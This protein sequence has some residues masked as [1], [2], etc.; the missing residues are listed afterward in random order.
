MINEFFLNRVTF[1]SSVSTSNELTVSDYISSGSVLYDQTGNS[2]NWNSVYTNVSNTSG[3]WNSVYSDVVNDS[4]NWDSVYTDVVNASGNWDSVY[5]DVVSTSANWNS[6]YTD[7]SNT[8]A[9]WDSVYTDVINTSGNWNSVYTDVVN[10]SGNWDSVYSEFNQNSSTYTTYNYVDNNFLPASGGSVSGS[11]EVG[12]GIT[13]TLYVENQKVGINTETPNEALT[14]VGNISANGNFYADGY[15]NQS[16]DNSTTIVENTSGNWNSV[17]TDVSNTSAE[18][19]S[20]YSDVVS[21]SGNWNSVYT[22]VVNTSAEWDSVYTTVNTNSSDNWDNSKSNEYTHTNFLPLTGGTINGAVRINDTLTVY[23]NI[24][25]TGNSYFSNTVYSTTSALSVVNIGNSGPAFYVGNNGSGDI[26]SFYDVDENLEV[27]HIGGN[28]GSHP[29]VGIKTSEPN[30]DLTINGEL[31]ASSTIWDST[32]NSNQWNSVYTTVNSNS[33]TIWNY[34]GTDIKDLSSGWV[35]GNSAF[36]NLVSNSAAYLSAV[37][38]SFLSVSGNWDSTYTTVCSNSANWN[39]AFGSAGSDLAVRGLSSGWVGGNTAFTNLVSNS[40]GYLS[41]VDLSFL[42]VSGNWDSTYTTVNSNSATIWNYQ[43]TDIKDLSSGWVGGNSAFTTV[44]SNSSNYILDGGNTKG[45]DLLIGTNDSFSLNLETNNSTKVTITSSGN[46]GIGT[47][48]PSSKLQVAYTTG[49]PASS[50]ISSD[51]IIITGQSTSPGFSIISSS[52]SSGNR[53]VFK[54]VRSRGTL[55]N[56]TVPILNDT[57]FSLLGSIFDGVSSTQATA[58]IE[59]KVDGNVSEQIAPQRISFVTSETTGS[60]RTEK[61]TIKSNGNVGIGT[62]IPNELLTVSGNISA[63]GTISS[64]NLNISNWNSV[65]TN[66]QT[67]SSK[68]VLEDFIVACSD[69]STNLT[70]TTSAVTFRVPF[71]MYLNSVRASVNQA[72]VGSTII[73]DVKQSGTSIFSTKLSIDANEETSTTAAT[74]A[75]ISN[76]NLTDDSKI[77]VS[78]DQVGSTNPGKGLKLTFKGYRI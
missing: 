60:A 62:L 54:C 2:S 46:V 39:A 3:N 18:W 74:P 11:F 73:V 47:I 57:T 65:Y 32:G 66:V 23:G 41:A 72:P 56:P 20:V 36:T 59:M 24:S 27:L 45:S 70:T 61:M 42:S 55:E 50:L 53:G 67:N 37:D 69:E 43:G 34:Q 1:L 77:I 51:A 15:N 44:N 49:T 38:L 7:V 4:G 68:W 75:V 25:A 64:S 26:A 22:D 6:V 12:S 21:T 52:N 48:D 14:I 30:K 17:Y 58:L 19:N 78:I 76:P 28:N 31:S 13:S 40:A 5:T 71:D 9:E 8:S 35:G 63:S 10:T 16:W 29:N 33:A